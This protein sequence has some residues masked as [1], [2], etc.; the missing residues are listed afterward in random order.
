MQTV[1]P[2]TKVTRIDA[3]EG[4]DEDSERATGDDGD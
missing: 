2:T 1:P 3:D 4:A